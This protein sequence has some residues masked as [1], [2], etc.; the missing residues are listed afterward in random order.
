MVGFNAYQSSTLAMKTNAHALNTIGQN[1]SNVNTGGYKRT[2]TYFKTLISE[3]MDTNQSDLGGVRPKD[4]QVIDQQGKVILR[5][6]IET[7]LSEIE[8]SHLSKGLYYIQIINNN[9]VS[10]QKLVIN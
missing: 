6:Q 2:D 10:L 1:I 4:Y 8:A 5:K 3:T 9:N 7:G